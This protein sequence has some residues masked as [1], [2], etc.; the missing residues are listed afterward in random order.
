MLVL[1]NYSDQIMQICVQ[2]TNNLLKTLGIKYRI[3]NQPISAH[4]YK[5]KMYRNM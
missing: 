3:T 5:I 4:K 2:L 1:I